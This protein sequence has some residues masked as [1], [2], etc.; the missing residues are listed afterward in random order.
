M[1][2]NYVQHRLFDKITEQAHVNHRK[3]IKLTTLTTHSKLEHAE[4]LTSLK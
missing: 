1:Y 3:K 4:K 2:T